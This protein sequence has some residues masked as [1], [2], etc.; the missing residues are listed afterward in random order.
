MKIRV[1][2]SDNS[3]P[4]RAAGEEVSH[5]GPL[6]KALAQILNCEIGGTAKADDRM[7]RTIVLVSPGSEKT[8]LR[9]LLY[10]VEALEVVK[11]HQSEVP[12]YIVLRC[13][14]ERRDDTYEGLVYELEKQ[15]LAAGI[16]LGDKI[17]N[18][19]ARMLAKIGGAKDRPQK[20]LREVLD[21]TLPGGIEGL[22]EIGYRPSS[23]L[24]HSIIRYQKKSRF[25]CWGAFSLALGAAMSGDLSAATFARL[26]RNLIPSG[27]ME[28]S[29]EPGSAVYGRLFCHVEE[30]QRQLESSDVEKSVLPRN[31]CGMM[32][33]ASESSRGAAGA[34]RSNPA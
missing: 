10:N 28:P 2:E 18:E 12:F 19:L 24:L 33:T 23:S 34:S 5:Q 8:W 17:G 16:N 6:R 29:G 13:Q 20:M 9:D 22:A 25:Q 15:Y 4:L 7:G 30:A 26:S 21:T 3:W 14:D 27:S 1:L 32:F 31:L 11:P